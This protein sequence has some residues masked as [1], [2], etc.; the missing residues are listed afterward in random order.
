MERIYRRTFIER[1][2]KGVVGIAALAAFMAL[3]PEYAWAQ[4][5]AK[6]DKRIKTENTSFQTVQGF[7]KGYLVRPANASA[8]DKVPVV[9]VV[10]ENGGLN[11]YIEDVARRL[12]TEN[13]M[14]FAPDGVTPDNLIAAARW[15]Q[16]LPESTGKLGVIGFSSGGGMAST[17]AVQLGADVSA[18]VSFYGAAPATDD[19]AKI[20]A[21][22]LVHHAELDQ[23]QAAGW[24]TYDAALTAANAPHE[25]YMYPN[26]NRGFHNNTTPQY[27]EAAA[28]LAWSR[29][30]SWLNKYLR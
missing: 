12:G 4:Q 11:P 28:K 10:S 26:A 17:L 30:V 6:N 29:T 7:V 1:C 16:A 14:V 8:I 24:P 15:L 2:G 3:A 21:A 25:G 19:V 9:V 22:V 13:F 5:V 27:D 20:K 23:A 18:A